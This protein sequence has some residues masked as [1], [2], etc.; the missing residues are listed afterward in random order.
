VLEPGALTP[1][2]M[3][4]RSFGDLVAVGDSLETAMVSAG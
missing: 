3:P 1:I 4:F 2:F